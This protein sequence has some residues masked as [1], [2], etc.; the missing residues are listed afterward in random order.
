[1]RWCVMRTFWNRKWNRNGTSHMGATIRCRAR[2]NCCHR[3]S[4]G[5]RGDHMTLLGSGIVDSLA[6]IA[7]SSLNSSPLAF[8][9][10]L[11]LYRSYDW[12]GLRYQG[13]AFTALGLRSAREA[14][15]RMSRFPCASLA[16]PRLPA[17]VSKSQP[18]THITSDELKLLLSPLCPHS[19]LLHHSLCDSTRVRALIYP[20]LGQ[21]QRG[22]TAFT[23]P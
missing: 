7:R 15:T 2:L 8:T 18:R 10:H 1:M 23:T 20:P 6:L 3:A 4:R 14:S 16:K 13:V 12:A 9:A 21:F 11:S 17:Q 5:L 19:F 22:G